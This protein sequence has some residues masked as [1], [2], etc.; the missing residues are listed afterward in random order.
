M[1]ISVRISDAQAEAYKAFAESKGMSISDF[2]RTTVDEYISKAEAELKRAAEE[3]ARKE[4]I[5]ALLKESDALYGILAD[6]PLAKM[7]DEELRELM[8]ERYL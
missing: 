6:T 3:Q 7:S 1:V 5:E 8:H 2:I 4:R